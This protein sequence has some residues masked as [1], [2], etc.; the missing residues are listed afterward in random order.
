MS[1]TAGVNWYTSRRERRLWFAVFVI[2]VAVYSSIGLARTLTDVF[3]DRNLIDSLTALA[4]LVMLVG[5][6]MVAVR[7]G[8]PVANI[9][10]ALGAVAVLAMIMLRMALPEERTHLFEYSVLT[11]AIM[12]ALVERRANGRPVPAPAL[13]AFASASAIGV[14]DELM[15]LFV[16]S[17]VFDPIDIAF[18]TMAAGLAT[19]ASVALGRLSP[20]SSESGRTALRS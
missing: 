20:G 6:M 9:G 10:V 12:E 16:P 1:A 8:T 7:S 14:A 19:V 5:V 2:V 15:Q 3:G 11:V 13:S 18:N 17:R 4:F